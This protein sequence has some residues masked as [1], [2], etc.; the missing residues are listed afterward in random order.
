M[1][2]TGKGWF[3]S[4]NRPRGGRKPRAVEESYLRCTVACVP[5][6]RWRAICKKAVELAESGDAK[7]RRWLSDLLV[8]KDPVL[9]RHLAEEVERALGELD[10]G[11]GSEGEAGPGAPARANGTA[12]Q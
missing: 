1:N 6:K 10:D 5:L 12:P 11:P 2:N 3:T 9:L 8:G 4:S 7:S